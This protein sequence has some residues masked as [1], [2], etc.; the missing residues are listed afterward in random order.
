M[1]SKSQVFNFLHDYHSSIQI[2]NVKFIDWVFSEYQLIEVQSTQNISLI[3]VH[4][5]NVTFSQIEN[6]AI[7][8]IIY[9]DN[10]FIYNLTM[11][12]IELDEVKSVLYLNGDNNSS[13]F[14]VEMIELVN[15]TMHNSRIIY[16]FGAHNLNIKNVICYN[17]IKISSDD[18]QSVIIQYSS[19]TG[20]DNDYLIINDVHWNFSDVALL[21]LSN[22]GYIPDSSVSISISNLT[23]QNSYNEYY[24]NIILLEEIG[25]ESDT[26]ITFDN[27]I[28]DNITYY[29]GGDLIYFRHKC[30]EPILLSNIIVSNITFGG[31]TVS[32]IDK[33]DNSVMPKVIIHNM[34]VSNTDILFRSFIKVE[35]GGI[36]EV[37]DSSFTNVSN[38]ERGAVMYATSKDTSITVSN[39]LFMNNTSIESAVFLSEHQSLIVVNDCNITNNLAIS[40]TVI[41]AV[42]EGSYQI[43]GWIITHN[44]ANH[45]AVT[46]VFSSFQTSIISNCTFT[47]NVAYDTQQ[48]IEY[49]KSGGKLLITLQLYR[50]ISKDIHWICY[51]AW[52]LI[53]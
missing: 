47:G 15:V 5:D 4:F 46:E 50:F 11:R 28:F 52:K 44:V 2:S 16:A 13:A 26:K 33:Q 19:Q 27:I 12:N 43:A 37:Y 42:D 34:N 1:T 9:S 29:F 22:F 30:H 36:A 24:E 7:F 53:D 10:L 18:D 8:D 23:Y 21:K 32:P 25:S 41:K 31:I 48:F 6:S 35:D 39:S 17:T 14:Q 20:F 38:I 45:A 40:S 3:G 49:I 51:T